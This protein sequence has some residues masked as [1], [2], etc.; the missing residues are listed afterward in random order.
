MESIKQYEYRVITGEKGFKE[1]E[2]KVSD[3]LNRG[4]KPIGG[5]AFNQGFGYQAMAKLV[6]KTSYT[7]ATKAQKMPQGYSAAVKKLDDIV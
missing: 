2:Q 1:L 4:W 7:S 5:I 3:L 6:E